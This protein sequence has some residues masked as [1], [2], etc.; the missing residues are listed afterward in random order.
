M[1]VETTTIEALRKQT[2]IPVVIFDQDG[3]LIFANEA[4]ERT[5]IWKHDEL[6]GLPVSTMLPNRF[7]SI[8]EP[9]LLPRRPV[10]GTACQSDGKQIDAELTLV[11]ANEGAVLH[12][13][14]MIRPLAEQRWFQYIPFEEE[15]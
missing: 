10:P 7:L 1:P 6:L 9:E 8:P 14:A 2:E 5:L 11:A 4:L 12:Y 15:T 13:G 3:R